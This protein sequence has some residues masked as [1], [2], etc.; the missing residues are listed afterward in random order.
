[1]PRARAAHAAPLPAAAHAQG[2]AAAGRAGGGAR[3]GGAGGGDGAKAAAAQALLATYEAVLQHLRGQGALLNAVRP[4]FLLP[5]AEFLALQDA[6]AAAAAGTPDE[7]EALERAWAAA[8]LAFPRHAAM[9]WNAL[10]LQLFRVFVLQARVTPAA[11]RQQLAAAAGAAA[12]LGSG[13]GG[14]AE[15]TA[16]RPQ[17]A[18]SAGAAQPPGGKPG[19]VS[20]GAPGAAAPPGGGQPEEPG[21]LPGD[22]V[23]AGS[24]VMDAAEACLLAWSQ[25][26]ASKA[27]PEPVPRVADFATGLRDGLVLAA[28]LAAHWPGEHAPPPPLLGLARPRA[29]AG[30][31]ER[32]CRATA[33]PPPV[34]APAQARPRRSC[35]PG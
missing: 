33:R 24:N 31:P 28:L 32:L 35:W 15:R 21:A 10:L 34:H 4:E 8:E 18:S 9:A 29:R 2:A 20:A 26:H 13:G 11:L 3:R 27:F 7:E 19:A 16:P 6:R 12:G 22:A 1:M 30:P 23:L 17:R 5:E 25:A 14:S